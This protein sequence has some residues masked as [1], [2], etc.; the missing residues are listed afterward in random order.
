MCQMNST[1]QLIIG[2]IF[3]NVLGV[4]AALVLLAWKSLRQSQIFIWLFWPSYL[5]CPKKQI[6]VG[7]L[8]VR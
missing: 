1:Q 4:A 2:H 3:L 7:H 8:H 5:Q 6:I